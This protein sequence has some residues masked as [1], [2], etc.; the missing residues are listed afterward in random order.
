MLLDTN[1]LVLNRLFQPIQVTTVRRAFSLLY[2]GIA[3]AIDEEFRLF[4]FSSWASLAAEIG[5]DSI[6]TPTRRIRVPRVV[7]L[8][9][10]D[11][12]PRTRVRFSRHNIYLR[13][14]NT[15][16]YCGRR[17]PR[18]EL[19]LDHVK[20]RSHGG[21]TSWENVVCSCIPCNLKK[22]NR[23]P[24]QAGMRLLNEP[25]R[26]KW[27]PLFRPPGRGGPG[28]SAWRP[29]LSMVDASYW[30]TELREE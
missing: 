25:I 17:L 29:F 2:Q 28:H 19:N 24:D 20:P 11:R 13:D 14:D 18:S 22:A 6:G 21:C 8:T 27:S 9:A 12:F 7:V 1:V 10:F 3:Q 15:C 16:Q 30:N 5:S 23:T 26:P 4:D